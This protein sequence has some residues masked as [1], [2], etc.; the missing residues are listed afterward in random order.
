MYAVPMTH[1]ANTLL[2][3]SVRHAAGLPISGN[4]SEDV[5]DLARSHGGEDYYPEPYENDLQDLSDNDA[6]M[7]GWADAADDAREDFEMADYDG[8]LEDG[9][10]EDY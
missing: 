4:T 6:I 9:Y 7:D 1:T 10:D 8:W 2:G 3:A 5:Y